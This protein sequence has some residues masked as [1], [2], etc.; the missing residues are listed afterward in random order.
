MPVD[1]RVVQ[2]S[3]VLRGDGELV[4]LGGQTGAAHN[5]GSACGIGPGRGAD[6]A[7][8]GQRDAKSQCAHARAT[9]HRAGQGSTA[10]HSRRAGLTAGRSHFRD[11]HGG[12]QRLVPD[13]A[14]DVIQGASTCH[15]LFS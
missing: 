11:G 8:Q 4:A 7:P 13:G 5:G 3:A 10:P 12:A 15:E 2:A 9:R 6:H 14:V 1:G